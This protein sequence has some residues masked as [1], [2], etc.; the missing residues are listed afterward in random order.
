MTMR[1]WTSRAVLVLALIAFLIITIRLNRTIHGA[2]HFS[3]LAKSLLHGQLDF[4]GPVDGTWSDTTPQGDKHHWPLGPFPAANPWGMSL[5]ITAPCFFLLAG[6]NYGDASSRP[7]RA[8]AFVI[9]LPIPF[10]YGIGY[11]PFGYRYS[12]DFLPL[13][14]YLLLRNYRLQRGPL[15]VAF[16]IV[17]VVS[18]LWNLHLFAGHFLWHLV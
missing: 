14:Y 8:T 3:A 11:R 13:L 4:T 10:Y 5:F 16:K 17:I 12:L 7:L 1:Q 15:T 9:A 6:L 18:A 2:E